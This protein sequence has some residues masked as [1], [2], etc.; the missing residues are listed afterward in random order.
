MARLRHSFLYNAAYQVLLIITPIITTPYLSR[1]LGPTGV[2]VYSFTSSITQY[3]VLFATLGMSTYGVRLVAMKR[4][5][6]EEL[7][8]AFWSAYVSKLLVS[9]V[10]LA[11]YFVYW[12]PDP[13]GGLA[14][15]AISFR[16]ILFGFPS[17]LPGWFLRHLPCD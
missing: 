6:R 9:A 14:T 8:K 2:G 11:I 15:F 3:F 12:I 13:K 16:S 17:A 4:H 5:N 1:V 7:S 10:V